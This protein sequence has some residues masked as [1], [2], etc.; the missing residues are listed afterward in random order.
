M[1][2]LNDNNLK[3][4]SFL[5]SKSQ[6]LA[7]AVYLVSSF[8]S[9]N[10]PIKRKLREQS[11][12]LLEDSRNFV[13]KNFVQDNSQ[14]SAN[15]LYLERLADQLQLLFS[16]LDLA[17]VGGFISEMNFSILRQEINALLESAKALNDPKALHKFI[18]QPTLSTD[19]NF[20]Q[21]RSQFSLKDKNLYS[22]SVLDRVEPANSR[23]KCKSLEAGLPGHNNSLK[24]SPIKAQNKADRKK[25]ILDFVTGRGWTSIKDITSVVTDCSEKTIQRELALLVEKGRLKKQGERR[26]SRYM[27]A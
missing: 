8:I 1:D 18:S 5:A 22:Q 2:N 23:S 17:M 21:S 9:D 14:A 25:N 20:D 6:R 10:D 16:C 3:D 26:W 15:S 24:S 12:S 7:K 27:L 19:L 13:P 11:L 4:S